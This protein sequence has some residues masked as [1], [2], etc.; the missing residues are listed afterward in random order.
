MCV[1]GRFGFLSAGLGA[2]I[3]ARLCLSTTTASAY[4]LESLPARWV[5]SL[6]VVVALGNAASGRR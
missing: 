5:P 4:L 6:S 1:I 2:L 3:G